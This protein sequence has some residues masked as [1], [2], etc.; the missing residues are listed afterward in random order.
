MAKLSAGLCVNCS[1][2]DKAPSTLLAQV[3]ILSKEGGCVCMCVYTY[4]YLKPNYFFEEQTYL[5]LIN[6]HNLY[7]SNTTT[8]AEAEGKGTF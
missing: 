6:F 5:P 4:L 8:S 3:W 7:N 1:P 2:P